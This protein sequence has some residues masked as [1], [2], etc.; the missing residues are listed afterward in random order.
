VFKKGIIS[1][2]VFIGSFLFIN[3]LIG[4][5]AV[6]YEMWSTGTQYRTDLANDLG[7]GLLGMIVLPISLIMALI[8]ALIIWRI[9]SRHE[10]QG[11][12]KNEQS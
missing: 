5:A 4:E 10:T 6:Y 11:G 3:Y 8:C 9:L 12:N 7:L 2:V 1:F